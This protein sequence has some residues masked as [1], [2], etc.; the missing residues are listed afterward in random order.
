ML[1]DPIQVTASI[2]MS[3][4]TNSTHLARLDSTLN[5]LDHTKRWVVGIAIQRPHLAAQSH[6]HEPEILLVKRAAHERD[7]PNRW[8]I[9]G[10]HVE[11]GETVR[12]SLARELFEETGLQIDMVL[13]EFEEMKW[14]SR[15][16]G[17]KQ[18]VQVNYAASIILTGGGEGFKV[19]LNADEHSDWIWVTEEKAMVLDMTE[20]M[21]A[22]VKNGLSFFRHAARPKSSH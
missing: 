5:D 19:V 1:N 20:E 3:T 17:G 9:P 6:M 14:E 22:V 11:A 7:F 16:L 12:Q 4:H 18:S 15:K 21:R 8:E 13:R 10:G 2:E